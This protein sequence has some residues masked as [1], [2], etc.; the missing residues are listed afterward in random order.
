MVAARR[1]AVVLA[2]ALVAALATAPALACPYCAGQGRGPQAGYRAATA[3][4]LLLP[5]ALVAGLVVWVRR[6]QRRA[7]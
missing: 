5:A 2:C 3:L 1:R 4:M 7:R 6:E